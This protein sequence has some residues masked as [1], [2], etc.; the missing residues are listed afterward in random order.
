MNSL[1]KLRHRENDPDDEVDLFILQQRDCYVASVHETGCN[2]QVCVKNPRH[3]SLM[4]NA[5]GTKSMTRAA[6]CSTTHLLGRGENRRDFCHPRAWCLGGGRQTLLT[7]LCLAQGGS[8]STKGDETNPVLL[9]VKKY[10]HQADWSLFTATP[11]LE[12]LRSLC[13]S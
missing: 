9:V 10:K 8:T 1:A 3:P 4:M 2:M 11:P 7:R 13:N 6:S 12:A 5:D